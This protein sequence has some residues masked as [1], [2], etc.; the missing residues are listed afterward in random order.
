[1]VNEFDRVNGECERASG[2]VRATMHNM[3]IGWQ[4]GNSLKT[5]KPENSKIE[6]HLKCLLWLFS[7]VLSACSAFG[8]HKHKSFPIW[9]ETKATAYII[10]TAA[11]TTTINYVRACVFYA[12][13]CPNYYYFLHDDDDGG[14]G[15]NDDDVIVDDDGGRCRMHTTRISIKIFDF[16]YSS[17]SCQAYANAPY[18]FMELHGGQIFPTLVC[19]LHRERIKCKFPKNRMPIN[20]FHTHTLFGLVSKIQIRFTANYIPSLI[21]II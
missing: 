17:M 9:H 20:R 10:I 1:M 12:H 16:I 7:V 21:N 15:G 11:A 4:I 3:L 5:T 8:W 2:S 13:D 18:I 14:G 19:L 6:R